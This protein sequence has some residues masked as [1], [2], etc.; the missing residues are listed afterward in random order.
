MNNPPKMTVRGTTSDVVAIGRGRRPKRPADRL[1]LVRDVE[2][3][4]IHRRDC[5]YVAQHPCED[6]VGLES[7]TFADWC[8]CVVATLCDT[9][10]KYFAVPASATASADV[11][12]DLEQLATLLADFAAALE[13]AFARDRS[14]HDL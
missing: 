9:L 12:N 3:G 8:N 13:H 2:T 14:R 10:S 6:F 7:T 5:P 4:R 1:A 11:K